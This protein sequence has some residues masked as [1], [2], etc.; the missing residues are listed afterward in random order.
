MEGGWL[1][2]LPAGGDA[3]AWG[4]ALA[5][6]AAVARSGLGRI[7][8]GAR[9]LTLLHAIEAAFLAALLAAMLGLSFLQIVLR[10]IAQTGWV[11]VDPLLR[12]LLLWIGFVGAMLATRM[13]Q[14]INVDAL[15]R[16][17]RP[18]PRRVV[19]A[20]TSVAAAAICLFLAEACRAFMRDEAA[21]GTT[22]FLGV[23]TWW[24]LI[25]MPAALWIMSARF[26]RHAIDAA[27]GTP[28][29]PRVIAPEV[30]A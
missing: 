9:L 11:W 13:N 14:H 16:L 7:G 2:A 20:A 24:L 27:R 5:V 28:R 18:G 8:F 19:H 4:A 21:A 23:P 1:A 12:H 10:N 26:V 30:A 6:A 22:G 25:V 17:L 15:S 29:P 3:I